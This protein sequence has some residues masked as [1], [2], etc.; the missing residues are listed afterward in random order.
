MKL[1]RK[2]RRRTR[3]S[4]AA[5]ELKITATDAKRRA[6]RHLANKLFKSLTL[7]DSGGTPWRIYGLAHREVWLVQIGASSPR[8]AP[9]RVVAVCKH[10]GRIL[11]DGLACDEG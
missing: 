10:T 8:L 3:G 2:K 9:T 7:V 1:P 5:S 4:G 6:L 11:Y